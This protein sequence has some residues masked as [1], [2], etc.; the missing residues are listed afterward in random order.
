ML[1]LARYL[2]HFKKEV[3]IGPFFKLLEAIFE[4]IVPLVMASI[5]DIGI[6][7]RDTTYVLQRGGII[8][9]LGFM[10]LVFAIICQYSAARASQGFGTM[11]R[12]DL[13]SHINTLS[14]GELDLLGTNSLITILTN[15]INQMQLAVAMLIRLVVRVPFLIIGAVV[16]SMILDLK[17]SIIFLIVA[18][19]VSAVIFLIMK[20][21]VPY[22]R[23][24]QK[25]LDKVSRITR[26]NL[27]GARVVRAFSKQEHEINR[28]N[29]ANN[30]VADV[31]INVGKISAFLNPATFA[32]LNTA[33]LAILWFGGYRVSDGSLTQGEVI[34]FVNYI[35]Q[36]SLALVVLANLVVIFT[37]A[38]ASAG[39]INKVF[40]TKPSIVDKDGS[41]L[42]KSNMNSVG[43]NVND[44]DEFTADNIEEKGSVFK[45]DLPLIS[46]DNVSFAYPRS[47]E[48]AIEGINIDIHE[49]EVIGI[50][51]GTGSGKST[52]INLLPR[53]YDVSKGEIRL[54]GI[55]L[56]DYSIGKLRGLFGIVAQ[57]AVLFS[58]SISDNLRY[59]K[60]DATLD[61]IERAIAIAQAK[62]FVERLPEG[63]DAPINQGGRNLSGGQRQRITIARALVGNP[64]ILIL[65]DSFSA[66]DYA[67]D[68]S[69]RSALKENLKDT[70][71]FIVSQ[72]ANTIK[73]ANQII[74]L[75]DGKMVGL[76]KHDELY[77]S[78]QVY[79]E[80]CDSQLS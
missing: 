42:D 10:G 77:E 26:E 55:P 15:D 17:L 48:Y 56:K 65:D 73:N 13:Y 40:D 76:G 21:S 53:F 50:I 43:Y 1:R 64:K 34:A 60:E 28:F 30:E 22:Y 75:D 80:I 7:N 62:E 66:L 11:V 79:K 58:G 36:I 19:L 39:R 24:R 32:I 38:A 54:K 2:K 27:S 46:I 71:V 70:T 20:L 67:T 51:G 31:A 18:P 41:G 57:K 59:M 3:I 14:Y 78:C 37:K 61:E 5:I 29:K 49:G 52:L 35:T 74:V 72:R 6:K 4:L 12:N 33:I 68:A 47:D 69:L 63:Y 9:L 45:R 8:L 25:M 16:M 23:V 44:S